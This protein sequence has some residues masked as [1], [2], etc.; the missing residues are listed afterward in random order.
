MNDRDPESA[1]SSQVREASRPH[2]DPIP[3]PL[4]PLAPQQH[5]P[6]NL[7]VLDSSQPAS[8][9][10][11]LCK[12]QVTASQPRMAVLPGGHLAMS[13]DTSDCHNQ[14]GHAPGT[15]GPRLGMLL[16]IFQRAGRS[17]SKESSGPNYQQRQTRSPARSLVLLLNGQSRGMSH[18]AVP[19]L[20]GGGVD[21]VRHRALGARLPSPA[22]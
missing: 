5:R 12:L 15:W 4:P 20:A 14:R 10:G 3:S 8:S 6:C 21:T 9:A 19:G 7:P 22:V 13:G 2:P 11:S 16:N 18:R 1:L 17:H